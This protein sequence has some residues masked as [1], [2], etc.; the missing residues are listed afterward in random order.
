MF[1]D[2]SYDSENEDIIEFKNIPYAF[3][4]YEA[5]SE[6]TNYLNF[7]N[8]SPHL[9]HHLRCASHTLNLLASTD[10]QKAIKNSNA[11]RIHYT[12]FGKCSALWNASRRPKTSEIITEELG[13]SLT[14]PCLTRWNSLYDAVNNLMKFKTKLNPLN[15]KLN[16]STFKEIEL[17]YLEEFCLL[18]RPIATALDCLQR[19]IDCFYGHLIPTLFSL[20]QRMEKL[21]EK[22][23]RHTGFILP[24]LLNSLK[25]R[26][27]N[28]FELS[29]E[30][31]EAI[32]ASSFHPGFKLR[33]LPMS[34]DKERKRIQ[35]LCINML[36]NSSFN[37]EDCNNN[38]NTSET[39][40]EFYIFTSQKMEK[41]QSQN[42]LELI[43]FLNDKSKSLSSLKKYP[44]ITNLFI[45][46]NTSL[47]SSAAVERLFSFA[48]FIQSPTRSSLS[49]D[50]FRKLIFLKGNQKYYS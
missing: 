28:Y 45:R 15:I 4:K 43:T 24:L 39:D 29:P 47:C 16:I 32:L 9:P 49:D 37:S 11:Q 18:M 2:N 31:N 3:D 26:F 17:E 50:C 38:G 44:N 21:Q 36:E 33:W 8:D 12:A 42:E 10:Y 46:F 25:K 13:Y 20:Q 48:G 23:L 22:N 40:D 19:E 30:V 35:N 1:L 7:T 41:Q 5:T 27:L 6:E 14:Y 34:L